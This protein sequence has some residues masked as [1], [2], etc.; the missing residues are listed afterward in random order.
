[1]SL[2]INARD[3]MP[4]GGR[5]IIATVAAGNPAA[6][7]QSVKLIIQDTGIGMD[8]AVQRRLFEPFFTTKGPRHGTGLGLST[9]Y[10]IVQQAG[11]II[12]VDSAEG[13]GSTFTVVF[14]AATQP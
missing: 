9:V 14:H 8:E 12:T 3:A 1:M 6:G 7:A 11:G 4:T 10:G 13:Q 2:A 5:L